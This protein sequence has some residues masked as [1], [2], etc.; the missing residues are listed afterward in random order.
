M[1]SLEA[2][3]ATDNRVFTFSKSQPLY[4]LITTLLISIGCLFF[5][6]DILNADV[7]Y[8]LYA[9]NE[10][11]QGGSYI[12]N[13]FETN[14]P[15]ILYLYA[16]VCLLAKTFG[17]NSVILLKY[18]ILLFG[19]LSVYTSYFILTKI[20][21]D[22]LIRYSGLLAL[23]L[24]TLIFPIADYGQREHIAIIFITPFLFSAALAAADKSLATPKA[25]LI[26]LFAGLGFAIK[27]FFLI[28][29]CL[30]E[31]Y[32]IGKKRSLFGW[33]R[34][35]S[36][37]IIGVMVSYFFLLINFHT[38]YLHTILP[39][40]KRYYY[41]GL[42]Q[43]PNQLIDTSYCLFCYIALTV[44]VLLY[45]KNELRELIKILLLA[46]IGFIAAYFCGS[47]NWFYHILP[48][49]SYS[50]LLIT[51]SLAQ[52]L[53]ASRKNKF[54]TLPVKFGVA[55]A[56]LVCLIPIENFIDFY[57]V[58]NAKNKLENS[59]VELINQSPNMGGVYCFAMDNAR[60]C[61]PYLVTYNHREYSNRYPSFWW[62]HIAEIATPTS[63]NINDRDKFIK[64]IAED[65]YRKQ[66]Q[67]VIVNQTSINKLMPDFNVINYLATQQNFI[68]EWRH[69]ALK[70]QFF[71]NDYVVY[72]RVN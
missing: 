22:Q 26:G 5:Q 4:L 33:V 65:L 3:T 30:C 11:L 23:L 59:L 32:L 21:Q 55:L 38:D 70:K 42:Q 16:P 45:K 71:T 13:F 15:L 46:Q 2:I 1:K 25:L 43:S 61:F 64:Y 68:N 28:P 24:T 57:V 44:S 41:P 17:L 8:L 67:W 58:T 62:M 48:A 47:A 14:P 63:T 36:L 7:A 29:L 72:E 40:V 9:S 50:I 6:N 49:E 52:T 20:T 34:T 39:L 54:L 53:T 35:E 18:Y 51:F 31:L 66:P 69:Y 60:P 37:I 12:H 56:V 27:P 10:M 19:L